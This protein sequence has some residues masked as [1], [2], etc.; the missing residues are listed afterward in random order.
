MAENCKLVV[1]ER[2]LCVLMIVRFFSQK[3]RT[4]Y[5]SATDKLKRKNYKIEIL[6]IFKDDTLSSDIN[7][8]YMFLK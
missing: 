1:A 5:V 7:M 4:C 8:L 6:Q 3:K 2:S